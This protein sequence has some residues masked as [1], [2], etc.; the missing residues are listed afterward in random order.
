MGDFK[1][2]DI[3]HVHLHFQNIDEGGV[4]DRTWDD[5]MP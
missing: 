4:T 3:I 1:K 5:V 2:E